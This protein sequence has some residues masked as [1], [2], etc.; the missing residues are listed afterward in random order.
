MEVKKF[1]NCTAMDLGVS[2]FKSVEVQSLEDFISH[3]KL[4]LWEFIFIVNSN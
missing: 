2:I 4:E 1:F 3:W